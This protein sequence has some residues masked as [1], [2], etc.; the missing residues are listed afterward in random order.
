MRG[1]ACERTCLMRVVYGCAQAYLNLR[2]LVLVYACMWVYRFCV[3]THVHGRVLEFE[4]IC[5]YMC[6]VCECIFVLY[7]RVHVSGLCPRVCKYLCVSA[8][9]CVCVR[10]NVYMNVCKRV[11]AWVLSHACVGINAF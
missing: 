9:M 5:V 2:V 7:A 6:S 1:S 8:S 4:R 3:L 11:Y 10:K